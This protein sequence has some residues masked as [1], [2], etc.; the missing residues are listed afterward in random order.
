MSELARPLDPAPIDSRADER[1][2]PMR[3][4]VRLATDVYLP[5]RG[6]SHP[7][8]L[9]RLPYD[10]AAPF[11]FMPAVAEHLT[12]RGYA[13]VCQDVRG[14]VRSEGETFAFV[15]ETAD[16]YDTLE[17]IDA[18]PWAR[19]GAI[20]MFGDSYYGFTQWAAAAS[21]HPSLRAIVPRMTTTRLSD[22]W[23]YHGGVFNLATMGDW[24]AHTWVERALWENTRDYGVRPLADVIGAMAAGRRSAS[25][26]HWRR[27]PPEDP[28][29]ESWAPGGRPSARL[30]IPALHH[31][32]FWD[33]FQRGQVADWRA[34]RDA[35]HAPQHLVL[36]A[37]DHFDDELNAEGDPL[38]DAAALQVFM[39]RY[40]GEP[41]RFFDEHLKGAGPSGLAPVRWR[42]AG[43]GWRESPDWPPPGAAP[44]AL[45]LVDAAR[46]DAGPVGGGLRERSDAGG[47][48]VRW[49]HDPSDMVPSLDADPWRPLLALPDER[50]VETRDDVLTFTAS[51]RPA[52]LDLV[53]PACAVLR[54]A[55]G[56]PSA[57]VVAKLC[58]VDPS[59]RSRRIL[60]GARRVRGDGTGPVEVRVDLGHAGYR[61]APGH[62]LRL[63]VAA[64]SFPRYMPHPGTD[65][66]PFT[67]VRTRAAELGL[68]VGGRDGSRLELCVLPGT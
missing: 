56:G 23:M 27:T 50:P 15:A 41:L 20:G 12:E 39:P 52:P 57:H 40:L 44:M 63:Q 49:V 48:I 31:G 53:G 46:A 26:D 11:S 59:G 51:A 47:G 4:G 3:D 7:V 1:M 29:W 8:V 58:D 24:A 16:G 68:H 42:L 66:D 32:G 36:D 9:V 35:G 38:A 65:E 54:L 6:G 64:S 60:E 21:G 55:P 2:V 61:I 19:A 22:D 33:V 14:K 37:T 67:A 43:A 13:V 34:A 25:F 28:W 45:H 17:W 62:R 18:Q 10:K 30:A 5:P